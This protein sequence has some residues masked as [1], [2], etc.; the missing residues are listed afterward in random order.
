MEL[1]FSPS[2]P[3]ELNHVR[4]TEDPGV[5]NKDRIASTDALV[6][7]GQLSYFIK[8]N[9]CY[10]PDLLFMFAIFATKEMSVRGFPT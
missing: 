5:F 3:N 4:D 7:R 2:L 9:F 6:Y 1:Q 8:R 10:Q